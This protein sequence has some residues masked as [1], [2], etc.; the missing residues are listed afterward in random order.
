[1]QV[2]E[3]GAGRFRRGR[4]RR[5]GRLLADGQ[6]RQVPESRRRFRRARLLRD[7]RPLR[8]ARLERRR[9]LFIRVVRANHETARGLPGLPRAFPETRRR[10]RRRLPQTHR[11]RQRLPRPQLAPGTAGRRRPRNTRRS[12]AVFFAG[13]YDQRS[14]GVPA[15]DA[16]P[17]RTAERPGLPGAGGRSRGVRAV[18]SGAV[19]FEHEARQIFRIRGTKDG[20][21]ARCQKEALRAGVRGRRARTPRRLGRG[22]RGGRGARQ[23]AGAS[24]RRRVRRRLVGPPGIRGRRRLG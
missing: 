5:Q 6:H 12:R 7:D 21:L 13:S 16:R 15:G 18:V 9:Q 3:Q 14:G 8:T 11:R 22:L 1:M 19:L 23:V 24:L 17:A 20:R 2:G 4:V 10:R